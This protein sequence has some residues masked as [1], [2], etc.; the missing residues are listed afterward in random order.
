MNN[1]SLLLGMTLDKEKIKLINSSLKINSTLSKQ[2]S[3][4]LS[5]LKEYQKS[6]SKQLNLEITALK[7]I[8]ENLQLQGSLNLE[9]FQIKNKLYLLG[10]KLAISD[11][12]TC[13]LNL[14]YQ[15]YIY[16]SLTWFKFNTFNN[17][18]L[19]V[20]EIYNLSK[21]NKTNQLDLSYSKNDQLIVTYEI[22][23]GNTNKEPI[24]NSSLTLKLMPTI[25][26]LP[27][28]LYLTIN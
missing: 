18:N 5:F 6:V 28:N 2:H 1:Y 26:K 21:S 12:I 24:I 27:I 3:F 10:G 23:Q 22:K 7:N 11:N 15:Q 9:P 20:T 4:L 16:L 8:S 25:K 14:Y 13:H 19:R 17:F